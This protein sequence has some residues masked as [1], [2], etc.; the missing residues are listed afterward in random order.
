MKQL[1]IS[2]YGSGNCVFKSYDLVGCQ[3]IQFDV[4]HILDCDPN[5]PWT[6]FEIGRSARRP[7]PWAGRA[8][9]S[10]FSSTRRL[11]TTPFSAE[12]S[13]SLGSR[14]WSTTPT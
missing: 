5:W 11:S 4:R 12:T 8:A 6:P 3:K 7:P 14:L 1:Y 9:I 2:N 10:T 13:T